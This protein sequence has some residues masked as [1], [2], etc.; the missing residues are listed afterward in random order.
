MC[1]PRMPFGT[2]TE[3]TAVWNRLAFMYT[4]DHAGS[5]PKAGRWMSWNQCFY[6]QHHEF[7]ASKMLYEWFLFKKSIGVDGGSTNVR[8]FSGSHSHIHAAVP[9]SGTA[10]GSGGPGA[11]LVDPPLPMVVAHVSVG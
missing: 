7:H 6:E 11:L 8:D 10:N 9:M 1:E 4:Y 3:R 2:D 5:I